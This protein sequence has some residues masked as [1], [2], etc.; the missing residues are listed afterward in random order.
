MWLR[1]EF[2]DRGSAW[3]FSAHLLV[4]HAQGQFVEPKIEFLNPGST[5]WPGDLLGSKMGPEKNVLRRN[6]FVMAAQGNS[7]DPNEF[8]YI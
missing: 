1:L 2:R 3:F 6:H 7:Q 4:V 5:F 8:Y